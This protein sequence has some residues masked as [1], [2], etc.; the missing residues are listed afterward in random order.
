V[1]LDE[2]DGMP[3]RCAVSIDNLSDAWKAMLTEEVTMLDPHRMNL[4]CRALNVASG[5]GP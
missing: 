1:I 4:V 5:C 3:T 2:D